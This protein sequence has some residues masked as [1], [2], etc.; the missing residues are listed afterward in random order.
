MTEVQ[1]KTLKSLDEIKETDGSKEISVPTRCKP[2]DSLILDTLIFRDNGA[3]VFTGNFDLKVKNV[4]N[5]KDEVSL[6]DYEFIIAGNNGKDA[7]EA[8]EN[9]SDAEAAGNLNFDFGMI[10]SD[11]RIQTSAGH[12]GRGFDG[13][14]GRDGGNGGDGYCG[15]NGGDGENA[16]AGTDGGKGGDAPNVNIIYTLIKKGNRIY[17]ND[18]AVK[19]NG[20]IS[21]KGGTGGAGGKCAEGGKGGI[22]GKGFDLQHNGSCGRD[23]S[24]ALAGKDGDNGTDGTVK[25][26]RRP[27][28][29]I[30]DNLRGMYILDLSDEEEREYCLNKLGGSDILNKYKAVKETINKS[31][32]KSNTETKPSIK[33]MLQESKSSY[34]TDSNLVSRSTDCGSNTKLGTFSQTFSIDL[35]DTDNLISSE[36]DASKWQFISVNVNAVNTSYVAGSPVISQN[37]ETT[38]TYGGIAEFCS[39]TLESNLIEG[40]I[41]TKIV[42]KGIDGNG[43][44]VHAEYGAEVNNA[45]DKI[46]Y[47]VQD[48]E[49]KDPKWNRKYDDG[50]IM[51]YGR[52]NEQE[53]YSKA[54]YSG[55]DYYSKTIK[56]GNKVSTLIPLSGTVTFS[57]D[58]KPVG[59]TPPGGKVQ[60]LRPA[61]D[62]SSKSAG[63]TDPDI[64]YQNDLTDD[65][66]LYK[67]LTEQNCFKAAQTVAHPHVDFDFSLNRGDNTSKLDWHDDISG[68]NDNHKRVVL[69]RGNFTYRIL[70]K[71]FPEKMAD[72]IQISITSITKENL[73]K[74][75]RNK[76][77]NKK[78]K[79][80]EFL[81]GSNLIYIPPI[82][83]YWGCLGKNVL[84]KTADGTLKTAESVKIGDRLLSHDGKTVTVNNVFTGRDKTIYRLRCDGIETLMSGAH[85]VLGE[86]GKGIAVRKLRAGDKIMTENGGM[87]EVLSVKEE[88]YDD[89][90]YNFTFEGENE[91]VYVIADGI[92]AGDL[93]AQNE[94]PEEPREN[95]EE[96]EK[97]L[98]LIEEMHSLFQEIKSAE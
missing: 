55:G 15:G 52:T 41:V 80:Y 24:P 79:Y 44:F 90:V 4:Y 3:L 95:E 36:K 94:M 57:S 1:L 59:L 47:T 97:R 14:K 21:L 34:I 8:G 73:E 75:N 19:K 12:G 68:E 35:Y 23:G 86:N 27:V 29:E 46:K 53:I 62:Y 5:Y 37:F 51:L 50:I 18:E 91:S 7:A 67:L 72:D 22:G 43:N 20:C 98:A 40:N 6:C 85:P 33:I 11:I 93:N 2:N 77:E 61:L 89:T 76:E 63:I 81:E 30:M 48:I 70:R 25:I 16:K 82:H 92:F 26:R 64:V 13:I 74:I 66:K 60:F 38:D 28:N 17:V 31:S 9:G 71:G 56:P 32:L 49:V 39:E 45:L 88:P 10:N 69:L 65:M 87:T 78:R 58:Y 54:D 84:L 83:I 42:I 96:K